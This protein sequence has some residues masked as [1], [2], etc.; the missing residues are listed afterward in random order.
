MAPRINTIADSKGWRLQVVHEGTTFTFKAGKR[1]G[2]E[3]CRRTEVHLERVARKY[4]W[5]E[6]LKAEVLKVDLLDPANAPAG[7]Q[8][9]MEGVG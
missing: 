6:A 7:G 5:T 2:A 4:G 1:K 3:D 8:V 9:E